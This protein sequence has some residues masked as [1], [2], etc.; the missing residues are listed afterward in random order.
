LPVAFLY[1]LPFS[2]EFLDSA[3]QSIVGV[4]NH[5]SNLFKIGGLP[6]PHRFENG[7]V[8]A[9]VYK[10]VVKRGSDVNP[11]LYYLNAIQEFHTET[12]PCLMLLDI[13]L[14]QH[15]TLIEAR[16]CG[17][18]NHVINVA[19]S[20]RNRLQKKD[21]FIAYNAELKIV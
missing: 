6:S 10:S 19:L 7:L 8:D 2:D 4:A 16:C 20:I 11:F 1:K 13:E 21:V 15:S 9:V 17:Q 18:L 12:P 14:I 5:L 3:A